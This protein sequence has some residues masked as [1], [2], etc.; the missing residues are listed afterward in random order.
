MNFDDFSDE[1]IIS[2]ICLERMY[3][4]ADDIH[5]VALQEAYKRNIP[6][7]EDK[8]KLEI[9]KIKEIENG[10]KRIDD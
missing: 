1:D 3:G 8:I 4:I 9:N 5:I 10:T 6:E 7:I 2:I